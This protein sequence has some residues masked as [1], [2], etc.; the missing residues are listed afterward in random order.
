MADEPRINPYAPPASD[1]SAPPPAP[2]APDAIAFEQPLFSPRQILVATLLGSLVAGIILMQGNFR[3]MRRGREARNTI[4]YGALAVG[5]LFAL[6]IVLPDAIPKAPITIA[7][8]LAFYKLADSMQGDAFT[9]HRAAGGDRQ[10]NWVVFGLTIGTA[11][12]VLVILFVAITAMMP[13][14]DISAGAASG[15]GTAFG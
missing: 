3:A 8:A 14:I 11:A 1:E 12:A 13:R 6:L 7:A 4:L 9:Q 5:A 10:S 15:G 2:P